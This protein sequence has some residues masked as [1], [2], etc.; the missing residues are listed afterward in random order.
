MVTQYLFLFLFP[1]KNDIILI[2]VYYFKLLNNYCI[3]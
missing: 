1:F 2:F 3:L